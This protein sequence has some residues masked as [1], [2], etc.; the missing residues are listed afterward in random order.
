MNLP[1]Q[2]TF[3]HC[4]E[5]VPEPEQKFP[6]FA[7]AG[8]SHCLILVFVPLAQVTEQDPQDAH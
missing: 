8:L 7:G 3:V 2:A 5:S 4:M 6:P 1:G